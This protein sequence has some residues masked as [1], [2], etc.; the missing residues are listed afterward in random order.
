MTSCHYHKQKQLIVTSFQN[1][2]FYLH[3]MP[4]FT[5]IHSLSISE[6]AISTIRF[7]QSGD[8]IALGVSS[9]GQLLVWE[10]H[11]QCYVL[12]QQGHTGV[13]NCLDHSKDGKYI[14]T[15]GED[16]KVGGVRRMVV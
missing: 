16:G 5:L 2:A 12:K 11:S 4:T 3:E 14:A 8:W 10:W 7:D 9:L 1:G 6:Q 15:G 13:A